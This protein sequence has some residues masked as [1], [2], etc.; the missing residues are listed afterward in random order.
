MNLSTFKWSSKQRNKTK[1]KKKNVIVH[2]GQFLWRRFY[3][4]LSDKE[5]TVVFPRRVPDLLQ[6]SS[7]A[8]TSVNE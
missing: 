7:A 4:P 8:M 3:I 1:A 5:C 2:S 6:S